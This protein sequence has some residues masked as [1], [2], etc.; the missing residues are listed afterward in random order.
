MTAIDN[1]QST[2]EKDK[3]P[4]YHIIFKKN[5]DVIVDGIDTDFHLEIPSKKVVVD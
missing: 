4:K 3:K 5:G 2:P 1:Q